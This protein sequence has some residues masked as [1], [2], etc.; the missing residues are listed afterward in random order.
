MLPS[1]TF[2]TR[3]LTVVNRMTFSA[4]DLLI[5]LQLTQLQ[6]ESVWCASDCAHNW[7]ATIPSCCLTT[8]HDHRLCWVGKRWNR[9]ENTLCKALRDCW[10]LTEYQ[11]HSR[12]ALSKSKATVEVKCM[13]GRQRA[14]CWLY[15]T[16]VL[17]TDASG[18]QHIWQLACHVWRLRLCLL[19][20]DLRP[21]AVLSSEARHAVFCGWW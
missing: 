3:K 5:W 8:Q 11:H 1:S 4:S 7:Q 10:H 19:R 14:Q 9:W 13:Q 21:V 6:T 2:L 15:T 20:F 12:L 16:D 17:Y 18:T